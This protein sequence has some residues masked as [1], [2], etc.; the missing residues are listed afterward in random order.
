MNKEKYHFIGL[1]GIGMSALARILLQQGAEVQGSDASESPLL[2]ELRKE[3]A[4]VRLG[5]HENQLSPA[6]TVVYS[7]DIKEYNVEFA[8]A[9]KKGFPML[10]RS[11]LL[12]R[13]MAK[14]KALLVTGTHGKTTTS[15]LLA[16]VLLEGGLDP[17][18]VVGGI[19]N[20][21][22]CNGRAGKGEYFVA[23]ADESDG[24][25]LKTAAHGAIVTNLE[26]DHLDYWKTEKNLDAAFGQFLA[27]V[28]NHQHLFW[29]KDDERLADLKPL[30]QSYGF[31]QTADIK[32]RNF[33]PTETGCLFD[34]SWNGELYPQIA[35]SIFGKHNALN[36]AAVFGL[37]ISLAIPENTIRSAFRT[38][39]GTRRR[40]EFKGEAHKLRVFDDYGHHPTEIAAT[41]R[42]LREQ[43]RERRLV[44]I[45][46]PHRFTRVRDQFSFFGSCF[47]D[48]DEVILTDIYASREAPIEGISTDILYQEMKK[49]LGSKLHYI[50]RADLE[51]K[52]VQFL[53]PLDVVITLGAGDVTD[54]SS[55]ILK[56]FGEQA[57]R[58]TVG[59]LCGGTSLEHEVSLRSGKTVAEGLDSSV[60]D[61]RLFKISKTG[62]W[63]VGSKAFEKVQENQES[64]SDLIASSILAELKLCDVCIPAFHGPEGEDGMIQ[65]FLD[66]LQIPYVGCDYRAA[67]VCMNKAWTKL[68][69]IMHNI[70]TAPFV[71]IDAVSFRRDP[72]RLIKAID[73]RNIQ[74]PVYIKPVHLGSTIGVVRATTP[75]EVIQ[76]AQAAFALDDSLIAEKEI[77]GRE[78]EVSVLG[79]EF[80]R[81][82]TPAMV[83]HTGLYSYED[84]YGTKPSEKRIPPPLSE[85]ELQIVKEL[86]ARTYKALGCKGLSR[87][88]FFLDSHGHFWLNEVNPFPGFTAASGYPKMWAHSG[89]T[90][91]QLCDEFIALA[92]HRSRSQAKIRGK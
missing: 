6:A 18:F 15:A 12:D 3:G 30:G 74:Y 54:A 62:H 49:R 45:F 41:L 16:T 57:P 26:N 79:N 43:V 17:S 88:D 20:Q 92:L 68:I 7:S 39:G 72:K 60:Y 28:R 84:K 11:E 71:E 86:A 73:E 29:C 89:L 70:P 13:L 42:A 66:T 36:A 76:A 24:S 59:V 85:T 87:V 82:A 80:V 61:V 56:K 23:E 25:F 51:T 58:L 2:Q 1:G 75:E 55:A 34:L 46:Q 31:S 5:H 21:F 81:V 38:F 48:A 33:H 35:L 53:Q 19:L 47:Q 27:L 67:S 77:I 69:A 50:P 14:K 83:M 65:G 8:A 40:L 44:A 78:L 63:I 10:H 37:S 32:I 64:S 9:K 22:Q 90:I 4:Q 52:T 91:P